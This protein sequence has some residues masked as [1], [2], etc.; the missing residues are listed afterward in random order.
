MRRSYY[1]IS[2]ILFRSS[3]DA[4]EV[5]NCLHCTASHGTGWGCIP[6]RT[7]LILHNG[8]L[9]HLPP[10]NPQRGCKPLLY[11]IHHPVCTWLTGWHCRLE[12]LDRC[13]ISMEG[14]LCWTSWLGVTTASSTQ[15]AA[16]PTV[17]RATSYGCEA[18]FQIFNTRLTSTLPVAVSRRIVV[19]DL[20]EN[21]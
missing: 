20:K 2:F 11:G 7:A 15:L 16:P 9:Q 21:V 12:S 18:D 8:V 14:L 13:S 10:S 6:T 17:C 3:S 5:V 4:L 19:L 1:H